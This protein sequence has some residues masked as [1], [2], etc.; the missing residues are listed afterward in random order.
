MEQQE[1]VFQMKSIKNMTCVTILLRFAELS[2]EYNT[3]R[4]LDVHT[5]SHYGL[6][7]KQHN[8]YALLGL[9]ALE[10][11]AAKVAENARNNHRTTFKP[12]ANS[13]PVSNMGIVNRLF[14]FIF[15]YF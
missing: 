15:L 3:G 9:K 2:R 6:Q 14:G 11:A 4:Q 10:R 12:I 1:A 8:K 13:P 7:A 5:P